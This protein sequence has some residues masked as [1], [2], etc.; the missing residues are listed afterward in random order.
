MSKPLILASIVL[1]IP[2]LSEDVVAT[3][4]WDPQNFVKCE[5]FDSFLDTLV[6]KGTLSESEGNL[7]KC[8][9]PLNW[10]WISGDYTKSGI[11]YESD[12]EIRLN[13]HKETYNDTA[14]KLKDEIQSALDSNKT[15][16]FKA[17]L[18]NTGY[19]NEVEVTSVRQMAT[20]EHGNGL[21]IHL[22]LG[23]DS[24]MNGDNSLN[25]NW[26]RFMERFTV[27]SN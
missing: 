16:K 18:T 23:V 26:H 22:Y 10:E 17:D 21:N 4:N 13:F 8:F 14:V 19:L 3:E 25:K 1:S 15:V 9:A 27:T 11:K 5:K 6:N 20:V 24:R 7:F 2:F 12:T